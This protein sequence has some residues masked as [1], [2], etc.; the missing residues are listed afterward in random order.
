VLSIIKS[1]PNYEVF[2]KDIEKDKESYTYQ[3]LK[4][5]ALLFSRTCDIYGNATRAQTFEE[6]NTYLNYSNIESYGFETMML[7]Q[8]LAFFLFFI[9]IGLYFQ[10]NLASTLTRDD[11]VRTFKLICITFLYS[12]LL[13]SLSI[14]SV[15]LTHSTGV[16]TLNN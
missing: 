2:F 6:L 10:N 12:I 9:P 11:K 8:I 5:E 15:V 4:R 1:I 14:S 16:K 7:I 13:L 3:L